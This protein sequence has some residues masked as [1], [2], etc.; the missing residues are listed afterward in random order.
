MPLTASQTRSL[1]QSP[2]FNGCNTEHYASFLQSLDTYVLPRGE[3]LPTSVVP[4]SSLI[5][6][7]S[8][9]VEYRTVN[10]T[11]FFTK[12]A[13]YTFHLSAFVHKD[14]APAYFPTLQARKT[15]AVLT[16]LPIA[17]LLPLLRTDSALALNLLRLQSES[18]YHLTDISCRFSASSPSARLAILLLQQSAANQMDVSFGIANLARTLDVSRATLYRSLSELEALG[19]IERF[20]KF[21]QIVDRE[22]LLHY[23]DTL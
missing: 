20:G 16:F 9:E 5:I 18:I 13:P 3:M 22:Q 19:L 1:L 17:K 23:L 4:E 7:L 12:K 21:I 11:L 8:G 6:L 15:I 14:Q 2:L 10:G